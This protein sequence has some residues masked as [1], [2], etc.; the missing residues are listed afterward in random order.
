M[1][2]ATQRAARGVAWTGAAQLLTQAIQFGVTALLARLLFPAEFGLLGYATLVTALVA[3]LNEL[4]LGAVLI[5]RRELATHHLD[6]AFWAS[7][8]FALLLWAGVAAGAP[9][10]ALFFNEPQLVSVLRALSAGLFLGALGTVHRALLER[11]L[12]FRPI[13]VM[14]VLSALLSGLIAVV[15]AWAGGKVWALVAWSLLRNLC[16]SLIAWLACPW[17]PGLRLD[18]AALRELFSF[19]GN[20]V[21]VRFVNYLAANIDYVVVGRFLGAASFG[22]YS[23]AYTLVTIPQTRLVPQITRVAFPAMARAQ[24]DDARLR[25]GYLRAV[26]VISLVVL[27][28]LAGLVVVAPEFVRAVYTDRWAAAVPVIR[29]LAGAG[30]V[31]ALVS[32]IGTIFLAKGRP[33]MELRLTLVRV[34]ALGALTLLGVRWGINGVAAGVLVF[35]LIFAWPFQQVANGLIGLRFTD[36]RRALAP[37]FGATAIMVAVLIGMRA[38][39]A[40]LLAAAPA[41]SLALTIPL[42]AAVYLASLRRWHLETVTELWA[43]LQSSILAPLTGRLRRA[44][45]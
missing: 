33:E 15:I 29:L 18:R 41:L 36:F 35:A 7:I 21:G 6:T 25:R 23:L 22:L 10:F 32:P 16:L 5:Q 17:R 3:T 20:V 30:I 37:A 9:I 40:P 39:A 44:R 31:Y 45:P 19:G 27:P 1:T 2:T 14:E 43:L 4:G 13:A 24:D 11:E 26:S 38:A 12:H 8:L 28:A 42:G 34:A